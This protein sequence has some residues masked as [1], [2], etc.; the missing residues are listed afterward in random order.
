MKIL[1]LM[2]IVVLTIISGKLY[3]GETE[4]LR[5]FAD[6]RKVNKMGLFPSMETPQL[7]QVHGDWNF[8]GSSSRDALDSMALFYGLKVIELKS[9]SLLVIDSNLLS[10]K[11]NPMNQNTGL[12][13]LKDVTASEAVASLSKKLG[14]SI[15]LLSSPFS[16][17]K[18]IKNIKLE[19][20]SVRENIDQIV[21]LSGGKFWHA[22][23]VPKGKSGGAM[24]VYI[25]IE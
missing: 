22:R 14:F 16:E 13:E 20:V 11:G 12:L 10:E 3:G 15:V 9:G 6:L 7:K 8:S 2:Q 19:D 23:V 25:V 5:L 1:T 4:D 18:K 17:P 24:E 21:R